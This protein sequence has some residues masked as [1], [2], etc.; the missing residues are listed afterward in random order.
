M[1]LSKT[2]IKQLMLCA[3]ALHKELRNDKEVE[4]II[5]QLNEL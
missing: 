2:Q 5:Q 1:K 3:Q 4:T